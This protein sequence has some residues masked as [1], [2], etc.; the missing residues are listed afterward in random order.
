[1]KTPCETLIMKAVAFH[2][3]NRK[4]ELAMDVISKIGE[5][6]TEAGK[7]VSQKVKDMTG[8][9][10]LSMDIKGKENYISKQFAAIGEQYYEMHKEDVE[11]LF[12]EIDLINEAKEEILRMQMELAELKGLK[13]CSVCGATADQDAQYCPKCG[14]K[15][16]TVCRE[17]NEPADG[18]EDEPVGDAE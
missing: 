1:M 9:A 7:D 11:P 15:Y 14:T 2:N 6:L 8:I 3:N 12:E 16:E 18:A 5:S 4:V 13:K 17:D 10:R